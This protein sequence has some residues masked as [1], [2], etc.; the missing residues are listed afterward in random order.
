MTTTIHRCVLAAGRLE[1]CSGAESADEPPN[2]VFIPADDMG[3]GDT[4]AYQDFTRNANSEQLL[5]PEMER[6]A[7]ASVFSWVHGRS[8]HGS[9]LERECQVRLGRTL[10]VGFPVSVA[11]LQ[12]GVGPTAI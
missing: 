5:T 3:M 7:T 8:G 11:A 10:G 12:V 4:I 1:A 2:I 9:S 6:L